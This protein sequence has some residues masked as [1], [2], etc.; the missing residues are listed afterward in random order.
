MADKDKKIK[1]RLNPAQKRFVVRCLA[2]FMTPSEV[3]ELI[4]ED[5][6]IVM[7][8]QAIEK[9]DPTKYA[10]QTLGEELKGLFWEKR[11]A[12]IAD[13]SD[14]DIANRSF[15]LKQL[16]MLY[17]MAVENG[18]VALAAQYLAQAA[19]ERGG[20]F[21]NKRELKVDDKR[22][23]LADMLGVRPEELPTERIM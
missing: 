8:R 6:K 15:R 16:S 2:E 1:Q 20:L 22:K 7:S 5:F 18:Q 21:T 23:T 11:K 10:G 13:E 12:F 17:R 3:A 4:Q 9:Y 19:K 14:I